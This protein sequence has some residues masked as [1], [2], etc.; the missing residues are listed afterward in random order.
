MTFLKERRFLLRAASAAPFLLSALPALAA[1]GKTTPDRGKAQLAA[2]EQSAGGRLGLFALDTAHGAELSF[3]ATE[4]FPVCSTGKLFAISAIL[5]RSEHDAALLSRRVVYGREDVEK[6]GYA[7]ITRQHVATG[8]TVA[9]LCAAAMQYSDNAAM[10]LLMR[11]LGGPAVVTAFARSIGDATFRLD[12]WEPELNSAIPGDVRDTSTPAAMAA[13]L[14][15]LALGAALAPEQR[16]QLVAWMKG[17][18]TGDKRLRAG[19]PAGWV[20]GDKT[21]TGD[22]GTSNDLGVLG[23]PGRAPIVV[24]AYFT[25]GEKAARPRDDV[26]AAAARVVADV[27]G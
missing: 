4:R 18:T 2:L 20:V 13:S 8:M 11:Q 16:G 6:S 27:L 10:N 26:L 12:R 14:R 15:R 19:V 1:Q 22:Y 5:K 3:R 25:Q 17:N 7:P 21:G 23:P 24:A 9:A